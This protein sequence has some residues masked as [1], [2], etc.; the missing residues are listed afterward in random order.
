MLTTLYL[1]QE[2]TELVVKIDEQYSKYTKY[3]KTVRTQLEFKIE[4]RKYVGSKSKAGTSF[5]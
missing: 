3:T 1:K 4:K 2:I 5:P